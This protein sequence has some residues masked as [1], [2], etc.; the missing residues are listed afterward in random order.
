M[1]PR[2][3]ECVAA[4]L[5]RGDAVLLSHRAPDRQWFPDV[6][7]L[8]GGHIEPD[9]NA[10]T[11]LARELREELGIKVADPPASPFVTMDDA[12]L[13]LRLRVWVIDAWHGRVTNCA[14]DEHDQLGWFRIDEI[15]DLRLADERYR[16]LL[17]DVTARP[18]SP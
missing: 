17:R 13:D 5:R 15:A 6:W 2:V 16:P 4:I 8:P 9:E 18:G 11:A 7:D 14:L 3:H 1:N 10:S 12:A